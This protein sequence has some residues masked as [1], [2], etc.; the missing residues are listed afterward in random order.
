VTAALNYLIP[1]VGK[2]A[3]CVALGV[4]RSTYYRDQKP[5]PPQK[6]RPTPP[7]ALTPDE[8]AAV[9]ATLDS[10]EFGDKAPRQVYAELLERKQYLCSWRT[11]YRIL[12]A[13]DQV[14]ERRLQRRHPTYE[15]PQ[16]VANA[17]NQ[18][19]SWD[20]T[21]VPGPERGCYY[22]LFVAIDIYSRYVVG[23]TISCSESAAVAKAFLT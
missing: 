6:P 3:A 8:R 13:A 1:I 16:L 5:R 12:A 9:L 19:W 17:P 7:R 14:R 11:M 2:S 15:K 4:S 22:T 21:K 18:V 20:T 23:W 10:D